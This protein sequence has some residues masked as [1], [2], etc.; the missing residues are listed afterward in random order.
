[1]SVEAH[2][3]TNHFARLSFF[4]KLNLRNVVTQYQNMTEIEQHVMSVVRRQLRPAR[5]VDLNVVEAEDADGDPI[6][7]V[8]VVFSIEGDRLDPEKVLGLTRHLREP[9]KELN[10]ERFPV[11]SFITEDEVSGATA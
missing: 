1:M 3:K 7:R 9:L 10:E 4:S 2:P 8:E 11:F 6:L 5:I